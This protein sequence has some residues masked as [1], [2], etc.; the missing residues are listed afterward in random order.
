VHSAQQA[1]L[2]IRQLQQMLPDA[3]IN[4]DLYDCDRIL[5]I[6]SPDGFIDVEQVISIVN[7]NNCSA[8]ILI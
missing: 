2:I 8:E 5:R 1:W 4:F 3:K 7:A 6:A